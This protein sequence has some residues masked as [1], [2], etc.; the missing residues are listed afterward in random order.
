MFDALTNV[1]FLTDCYTFFIAFYWLC[2]PKAILMVTMLSYGCVGNAWLYKW[3]TTL[4]RHLTV[5]ASYCYIYPNKI[6]TDMRQLILK[7]LNYYFNIIITN[8]L[9]VP[10]FA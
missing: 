5:P 2:K 7:I 8:T 4:L 1:R 9:F 10:Y 6:C 3:S